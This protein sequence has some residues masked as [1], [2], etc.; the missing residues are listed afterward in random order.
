MKIGVNPSTLFDCCVPAEY[1]AELQAP[2]KAGIQ[3]AQWLLH[4]EGLFL[5]GSAA[6]N[7]LAA[8]MAAKHLGPGHVVVTFLCDGG[9]RYISKLY[10]KK[11]LEE[12]GFPTQSPQDLSFADELMSYN[13]LHV[14]KT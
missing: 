11:W 6:F 1:T 2:D 14:V 4:K 12:H 7:A 10:N 5:G 13:P 8:Y 9:L 3:M